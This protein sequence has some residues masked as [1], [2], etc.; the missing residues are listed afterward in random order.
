[1]ASC[2]GKNK[3]KEIINILMSWNTQM[4]NAAIAK[5]HKFQ[6]KSTENYD[7]SAALHEYVP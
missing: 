6:N 5:Q 4:M 1:M 3:E 7:M 2:L